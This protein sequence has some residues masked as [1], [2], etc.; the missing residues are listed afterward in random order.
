MSNEDFNFGLFVI[1]V[2][3]IVATFLTFLWWFGAVGIEEM[4]H[5]TTSQQ[6]YNRCVANS[7]KPEECK[8][9]LGKG[10]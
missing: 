2:F 1:A 3:M 5:E 4:R 8:Y 10:N 9:V 6:E 7:Y